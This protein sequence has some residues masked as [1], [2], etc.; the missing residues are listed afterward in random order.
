MAKLSP[1]ILSAD[2]GILKEQ[3]ELLEKNGVE[4]IHIDI[5]DGSFVPNISM[6]IPVIKSIR[7]YT[8]MIFDT[9]IMIVN[10]EKYIKQFKEAGCDIINVHAEA[11]ENL[12]E[13]IDNINKLGVK[14]G[15]TIKPN[16]PVSDIINVLDKVSLVLIMTVEPGFGG[17]KFIYSQ[18]EKVDELVKLR[19]KNNYKYKIEVD[20]GININNI[21]NV[22]SHGVDLVVAG[23]AILESDNIEKTVNE[24]NN[25]LS[26][27]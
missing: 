17:Q 26:K 22:V 14:S 9:H 15:V 6:G 10:P 2:F 16:T 11:C 27:F 7:K 20:G 1:S 24:F 25:I 13:T 4:Y 8:N 21:Q 23:S 3:L 5:M 19:Q 12:Y 18:L